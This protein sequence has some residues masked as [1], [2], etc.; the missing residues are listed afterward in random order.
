MNVPVVAIVGRPNVGKSSLF[1]RVVGKRVAVVED[2]PG[3]TRDRLYAPVEWYGRTFLLVDTGG[4]D[5]HPDDSLIEQVKSQV[6][7]AVTEASAIWFVVDVI[8]GLAP[9]DFV[10]ADRLRTSGKAVFVVAHK[11]DNER[12]DV[13]ASEVYELGFGAVFPVSS[14]H[15]RGV[16]D[17]LEATAE[18]L[19]DAPQTAETERAP[20]RIAV[21]GRPNAGKS[22]I[23]NAL[24]GEARIIVDER[25]GTTRDA[26][27]VRFDWQDTPFELVDTAGMRRRSRIEDASVEQHS[28]LRAT[29]SV[30]RSDVTWLVLDVTRGVSHQD[31][32]I[33]DFVHRQ[34]KCCI[35]VVNKW[36]LIEKDNATFA[37]YTDTIRDEFRAFA[38]M[39]I[40]F[41]SAITGQRIRNLLELSATLVKASVLR[42]PTPALNAFFREVLIAQPPPL[43]KNRRLALK[44]ITQVAVR[45]P[46]FVVFANQPDAVPDSYRRYLEKRLRDQ[47]GFDGVPL[48]LWFRLSGEREMT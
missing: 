28:V 35:L 20:I 40:L 18:V 37:R 31:K 8:S 26:V 47:F 2:T 44:Y 12:L 23:V 45:P 6:E 30:E 13:K 11:A 19:P 41:T 46:S 32:T 16:D 24:L 36:D 48:R 4:L 39:P 15:H 29:T 9:D 33:A 42:I 3:V 34:G 1:N 5:P 43:V 10:V 27:N 25:P 7:I 22:S 17:L 38:Y 14:I 21:V